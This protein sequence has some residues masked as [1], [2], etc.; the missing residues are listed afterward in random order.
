MEC[1][2]SRMPHVRDCAI[3]VISFVAFNAYG[4][5]KATVGMSHK[6][7]LDLCQSTF[8]GTLNMKM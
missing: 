3:S 1:A 8:G 4:V 7:G 5:R 2:L 6:E